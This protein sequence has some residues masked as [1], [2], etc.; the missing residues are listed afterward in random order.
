MNIL[1]TSDWHLGKYLDN[2]ER[3]PEQREAIAEI[4]RIADERGI[5]LVLICG[6]IF[7]AAV[8]S[9]AAE[10]LF[11]NAIERLSA[12]GKRGMVIIAGNHDNPERLC[13]AKPLADRNGIILLGMPGAE[14]N[15]MEFSGL[16]VKVAQ[17]GAGWLELAIT[18]VPEHA[19]IITLPY[20]S[21]SRLAELLTANLHE[22]EM[23]EAYAERVGKIFSDLSRHFRA[24]TVNLAMS[25]LFI[26]GGEPSDSERPIQLGGAPVVSPDKLPGKA[27]Y[28]ALGHLHKSQ[29]VAAQAYYSGSLL[30]YSF[31][32][33]ESR[34]AI[35]LVRVSPGE[36]ANIERIQLHSGKPLIRWVA[37]NGIEEVIGWCK[38]GKDAEAWIDLEV[39]VDNPLTQD[40]IRA[41]RNLRDHIVNIWPVIKADEP[42]VTIEEN[43]RN[44]PLPVLF[45]DF[46]K[47]KTGIA[48]KSELTRFFLEIAAM[49]EDD[50]GGM[51]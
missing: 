48:P 21:E 40:Q 36:S 18:G 19:V 28:I 6:D 44:K 3:L 30:Q 27:Q 25:H 2:R 32:E 22:A 47:A 17:S 11:Y 16:G 33:S 4:C 8:P 35:F 26:L 12:G 39:Y 23:G 5:H 1:H 38:E 24:D 7:D 41:L 29:K 49:D 42:S 45:E 50:A 34:K 10:E 43:R 9:A 37:Q 14:A 15:T 13:A 20:P 31:A 51:G 46:Y